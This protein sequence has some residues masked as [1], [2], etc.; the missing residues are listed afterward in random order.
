MRRLPLYARTSTVDQHVEAQ[1]GPLREWASRRGGPVAEYA[2]VGVS[3]SRDRRPALDRL[4]RDCRAGRVEVVAI[5]KLDRA[6]RSLAHLVALVAELDALGVGLVV[7]D[8]AIDTGTAHGRLLLGVLGAVGQFER[9]L[10]VDRTRA[11]LDA[12]RRRGARLGRPP[13]LAPDVVE[14]AR[15]LRSLGASWRDAAR[16]VGASV[17]T[18]RR[19]LAA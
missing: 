10:I 1:L 16:Q 3:G 9:D 12:A 17:T 6:A 2:D 7:L 18:L 11:G 14:R 5:V 8:Q 15:A 4:M 13:A 19:A